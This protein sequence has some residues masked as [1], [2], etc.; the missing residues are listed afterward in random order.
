MERQSSSVTDVP[1]L[2]SFSA[3]IITQQMGEPD[4]I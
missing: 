2:S 1:T 4:D 3:Y